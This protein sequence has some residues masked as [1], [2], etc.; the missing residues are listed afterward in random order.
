MTNL[1]KKA[2]KKTSADIFTEAQK[3][4]LVMFMT[5]G[6]LEGQRIAINTCGNKTE[7]YILN[8]DR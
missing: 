4:T 8:N 2:N 6:Y 7:K 5:F 1:N 3:K